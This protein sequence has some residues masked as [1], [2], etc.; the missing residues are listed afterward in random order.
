MMASCHEPLA[1]RSAPQQW[2]LLC[3]ALLQLVTPVVAE[4][5]SWAGKR[6]CFRKG[7]FPSAAAFL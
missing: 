7:R 6:N 1:K 2:L 4:I 3:T 5:R